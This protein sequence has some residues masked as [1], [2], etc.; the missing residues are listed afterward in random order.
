[1]LLSTGEQ[2]ATAFSRDGGLAARVVSLWGNPFGD[3][4]EET[5]RDVRS[6][7]V[8][9]GA[10]HG[11]AGPAY[12]EWLLAH[13]DE[14]PAWRKQVPE[15]A[16]EISPRLGDAPGGIR[17]RIATY[18]AI[19][20]IT[21]RTAHRA[22]D[23]PWA[24]RSV[25]SDVIGGAAACA[26]LTGHVDQ[27]LQAL[28]WI[29]SWAAEQQAHFWDIGASQSVPDPLFGRWDRSADSRL[30]MALAKPLREAMARGGFS[31]FDALMARFADRGW[32]ERQGGKN[33]KVAKI[34]NDTVKVCAIDLSALDS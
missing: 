7:T 20:E 10:N 12:I 33:R 18:L 30:V 4:N 11:A 8:G 31:E 25:A 3:A 16:A 27:E 1:V 34:L 9:L 24:F 2:P 26:S 15:I 22:L 19:L 29:A 13:R 32:L 21:Q 6:I 17:E 14:W 28:E 23:L 5:A